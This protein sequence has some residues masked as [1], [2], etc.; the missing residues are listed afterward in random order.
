MSHSDDY[1]ERDAL[2]PIRAK[3]DVQVFQ[4]QGALYS[5]TTDTRSAVHF[6]P[7][8]CPSS[9]PTTH[10]SNPAPT[11]QQL[12]ARIYHQFQEQQHQNHFRVHHHW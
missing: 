7:E 5:V 11:M 3:Q 1:D 6:V 4:G 12:G 8:P 2:P 9:A 10:A